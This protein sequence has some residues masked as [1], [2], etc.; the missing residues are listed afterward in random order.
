MAIAGFGAWLLVLS[1][2]SAAG[3][4][5]NF[6]ARVSLVDSITEELR[7]GR[8]DPEQVAEIFR[9][10]AEFIRPHIE[11]LRAHRLSIFAE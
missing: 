1:Y 10:G 5:A 11:F 4:V 8:F 7:A 3:I 6:T 9:P 2:L